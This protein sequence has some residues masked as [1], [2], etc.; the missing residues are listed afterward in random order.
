MRIGI[1]THHY[2]KNFGAYM[3]AKGLLSVISEKYPDETIELIDYRVPTHERLN[4]KH[5]FGFKPQRGDTV[6]GFIQKMNLFFTHRKYEKNLP[7]SRRVHTVEEINALNYDLLIIGSD[8]VWDFNDIA[9]SPIKFGNGIQCAHITY[10]ASIGGSTLKDGNIPSAV[11]N[12]IAGFQAIAVRDKNTEEL[13]KAITKNPV[14]RTLDPVYLY[15]YHL[16]VREKIKTWV[17][18]KPYILIYDC[19]L[20]KEQINIIVQ[21]TQKENFNILGAGEYRKWYTTTDTVNITPY[22]WAY[23]FKYATAVVT[24]TFHGTSFAIKY[25]RPFAVYLTEQNRINK[26]GSLL[27]EFGLEKQIV[28]DSDNIITIMMQNIDYNKINE[29]IEKRM[30]ESLDYLFRNIDKSIKNTAKNNYKLIGAYQNEN[31][32]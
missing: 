19:H 6:V 25:N 24:G 13:V 8:E 27:A 21:Y 9:Y 23:L 31:S 14:V 20:G 2:V 7:K 29:I 30:S 1:L 15:E 28:V 4:T 10:S 22:E 16:Q 26:V 3:Q 11:K 17:Y 5:F 18:K 32:M 12:G